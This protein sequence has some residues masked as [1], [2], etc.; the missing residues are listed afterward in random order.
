M[1]PASLFYGFG[2]RLLRSW[3]VCGD[4][5]DHPRR[6]NASHLR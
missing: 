6:N 1:N 4:D 3:K 2:E 5:E